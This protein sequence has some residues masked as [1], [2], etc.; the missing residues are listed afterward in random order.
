MEEILAW[1]GTLPFALAIRRSATLYIFVNAAHILSIGIVIGAILPLDLRLIGLIRAV[2]VAVVGPFL[3]HAAAVGVALAAATG[4]C[5][6]SV[7]PIEYV[8]NAA[9]LAKMTLLVLGVANAAILH[10]SPQWRAA[11]KG[12]PIS[13]RVRLSAWLSLLT[14]TGAVVAGRW[15]GFLLE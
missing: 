15:I 8:G 1:I 13:L 3:S 2:P 11:V 5:L 14:W 7:N 6:F 9:F 4:F 10:L 12:G